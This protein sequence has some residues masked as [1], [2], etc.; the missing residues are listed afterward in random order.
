M[1][2]EGIVSRPGQLPAAVGRIDGISR[3]CSVFAE[4]P[5][6]GQPSQTASTTSRGF[7]KHPEGTP[8]GRGVDDR[9]RTFHAGTLPKYEVRI[10]SAAEGFGDESNRRQAGIDRFDDSCRRRW[11]R[12][13]STVEW[14]R[15]GVVDIVPCGGAAISPSRRYFRTERRGT[16]PVGYQEHSVNFSVLPVY[17]LITHSRSYQ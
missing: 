4:H 9:A 2:F 16:I 3:R 11:G 5:L 6:G 1:I 14:Y 10:P 12:T 15:E 13:D 7:A 17:N 8:K